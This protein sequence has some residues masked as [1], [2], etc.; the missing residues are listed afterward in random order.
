MACEYS[1]IWNDCSRIIGIK[2]HIFV[3]YIPASARSETEKGI[4]CS[5]QIKGQS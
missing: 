3:S 5:P 1:T 2:W 4:C